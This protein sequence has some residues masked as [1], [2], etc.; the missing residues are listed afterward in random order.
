MANGIRISAKKSTL[1]DLD[2][3]A[4]CVSDA[5]DGSW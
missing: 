3:M 5:A 1:L 2:A 4:R